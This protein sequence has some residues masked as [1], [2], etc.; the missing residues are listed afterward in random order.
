MDNTQHNN[1]FLRDVHILIRQWPTSR[2]PWPE[3]MA[4]AALYPPP[5]PKGL[6][7][8]HLGLSYIMSWVLL[9]AVRLETTWGRLLRPQ[10]SWY[11]LR[12]SRYLPLWDT[13]LC[14]LNTLHKFTLIYCNT[15]LPYIAMFPTRWKVQVVKFH[16]MPFSPVSCY[17]PS[18]HPLLKHPYCVWDFRYSRRRIWRLL[19]SGKLRSAVQWKFTDVLEVLTA[20]ITRRPNDGRDKCLWNTSKRLPDCTTQHPV[21]QSSSVLCDVAQVTYQSVLSCTEPGTL[22]CNCHFRMLKAIL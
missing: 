20:S 11:L 2:S 12:W 7:K 4:T 3:A 9:F 6:I 8:K 14:R 22:L 15:A 17:F 13:F 16:I 10:K 1:L 18:Q 21:R 5:P 19:S